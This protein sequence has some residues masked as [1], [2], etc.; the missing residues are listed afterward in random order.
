MAITLETK[1]K[2]RITLKEGEVME[3]IPMTIDRENNELYMKV[4]YPVS[5][6][7]GIVL[8]SMEENK[9]EIKEVEM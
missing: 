2:Y 9:N 8:S 5:N 4:T 6:H 1:K 7:Q 3:F